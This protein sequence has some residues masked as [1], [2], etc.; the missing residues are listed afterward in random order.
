V[1]FVKLEMGSL[2]G[3]FVLIMFSLYLLLAVLH[4]FGFEI[5]DG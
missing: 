1:S 5:D 3:L 2:M 4:F